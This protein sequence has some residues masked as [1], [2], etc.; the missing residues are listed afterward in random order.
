MQNKMIY[1]LLGLVLVLLISNTL[2]DCSNRERT[3]AEYKKQIARS[4][5]MAED[6]EKLAARRID[7]T[8]TIERKI[9]ERII[10]KER[11]QNEILNLTN[12]DSVIKR[13]YYWRP[14]SVSST[15]R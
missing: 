6:L 5:Q 1:L 4:E 10:E 7:S 2:Q 9:T 3:E 11:E 8:H 12:L 15:D 13:Y 14:D